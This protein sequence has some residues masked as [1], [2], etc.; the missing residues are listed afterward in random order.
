MKKAKIML[1]SIA[2]LAVVGG[3]LAFKAKS[4]IGGLYCTPFTFVNRT[5]LIC[6]TQFFPFM[7][8]VEEYCNQTTCKTLA[9]TEVVKLTV[10]QE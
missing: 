3:A 9:T 1:V 2:V 5:N 8:G 10:V 6:T 7:P 4:H